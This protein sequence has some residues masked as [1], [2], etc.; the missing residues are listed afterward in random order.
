MKFN[1]DGI[2]TTM[3]FIA[4][5]KLDELD[6]VCRSLTCE[7]DPHEQSKL[8]SKAR[9]LCVDLIGAYNGCDSNDQR[10]LNLRIVTSL[11]KDVPSY[12]RKLM[13]EL[14]EAHG[15]LIQERFERSIDKLEALIA[16]NEKVTEGENAERKH[17]ARVI[18]KSP[19]VN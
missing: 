2:C 4:S 8:I 14:K 15:V 5:G 17:P 10:L 6:S 1:Y 13:R 19:F 18:P 3:V 11:G 9:R 7:D 12:V 16:N